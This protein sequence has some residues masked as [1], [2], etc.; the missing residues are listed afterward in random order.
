MAERK[1][2]ILVCVEGEKLDVQ[3]ME[4]LFRL[5]AIDTRH[6]IVPYKTNIY[7]LYHA[8]FAHGEPEDFD[9]LQVL[10]E[11]EPA[12]EKKK[13]LDENFSDVL[14][15]FDMDPQDPR[16]SS[17]K[18]IRMTE[19]FHEST[20][21][22]KLYLNYPMVEAFYHMSA[23]PD[24]AYDNRYATQSELNEGTYKT[25]VRRESR[26]RNAKKFA[27]TK[28]ECNTVIIQNIAKAWTLSG[29]VATGNYSIP[30][31]LDILKTQLDLLQQQ[32]HVAVLSTCAFFI[33][34]YN[35]NLLFSPTI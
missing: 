21:H 28:G 22:G 29:P 26:D 32:E 18:L 16:F 14:L 27:D 6:E 31:Q 23:I 3:L 12:E 7:V 30:P 11:R 24:P 19:F 9:L 33:A 25:R 13:L 34:E 2:K 17:E 10:K 35:A 5:Y 8:M 4:H 1:G 20:D 15:I